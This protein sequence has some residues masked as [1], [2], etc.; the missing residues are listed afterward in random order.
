MH[1]LVLILSALPILGMTAKVTL[2]ANQRLNNVENKVFLTQNF[3]LENG[4]VLPELKLAYETYGK[5]NSSGRN[6]VL[7]A[8]GYT[9][10]HHAA[11][12]RATGD[13]MPG[14]WDA[15][16]GPGK[17]IDTDRLFVVSSNMLGSS[18]GSTGPSSINPATSKPYGPDFPE[19]SLVDI[20]TAQRALL[21]HLGV[22]HLVAVAGPSYGGY[23][24]FQWGVTFP[25]FMDG[26]V[27][28]VSAPKG[29]GGERATN[30]LIARLA[31]DPHWNGGWFYDRGGIPK[32]LTAMRVETLKRY[33][34]EEQLA[35]S[36][37][38][39]KSREKAI[40]R[41]AEPWA[42]AFDGNSLV[43]LRRAAVRFNA[44]K[45]FSK[46]R[47]KVLY[48]LSRT[49]NLFPPSI[50]PAV[51]ENLKA[52]KVDATYCE[53]DSNLGHLASG[54][55]AGKW[56]STLQEFMNRLLSTPSGKSKKI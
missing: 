17:P 40:R 10:D 28:A 26:L 20:V 35:R 47:A 53:I 22:K 54:Q 33:G 16:I 14:W 27:A 34:I 36:I 12:I 21:A 51:M 15:L 1:D 52:A 49:D 24:A 42:K 55:D 30:D 9:S 3:R 8:H 31:T 56:A 5:L 38:D 39:S 11:G 48:A 6:C 43:V 45:D 18:F 13:K 4:S 46:I 32:L 41:L 44:E 50:A 29:S 25:D 37:P 23:Q 2:G 7:A 19:I